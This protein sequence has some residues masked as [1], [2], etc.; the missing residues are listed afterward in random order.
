METLFPGIADKSDGFDAFWKL[1]P[2]DPHHPNR[3]SG[4]TKCLHIWKRDKLYLKHEHVIAV[5][6]EDIENIKKGNYALSK[7]SSHKMEYFPGIQP[8]LNGPAWDR[9]IEEKKD[10]RP[11]SSS[12][13]DVESYQP[14]KIVREVIPPEVKAEMGPVWRAVAMGKASMLPRSHT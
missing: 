5:L 9:D 7:D 3:K 11:L 14:K 6:K 8:W 13:G 1:Y 2:R 4:K 12:D 10:K